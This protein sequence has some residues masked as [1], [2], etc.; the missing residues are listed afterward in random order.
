MGDKDPRP[1]GAHPG[2]NSFMAPL[3]RT[4]SPSEGPASKWPVEA[5]GAVD[6]EPRSS[7][8]KRRPPLLGRRHTDAGV[9][10]YHRPRLTHTRFNLRPGSTA[11]PDDTI[12]IIGSLSGT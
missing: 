12:V 11:A 3:P 1:Q 5:A 10:R 4:P 8:P 6:G 9:H 7:A 2:V